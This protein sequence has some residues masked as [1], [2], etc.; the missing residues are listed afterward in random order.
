M[1]K[2]KSNKEEEIYD[3]DKKLRD[4]WNATLTAN[5][6]KDNKT[7]LFKYENT[8]LFKTTKIKAQMLLNTLVVIF[9]FF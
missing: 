2:G 1:S 5:P 9:L 3:S 6:S 8:L 4:S 7:S